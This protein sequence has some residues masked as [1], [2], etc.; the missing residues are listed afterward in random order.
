[1]GLN[2]VN[3]EKMNSPANKKEK[4]VPLVVERP[5]REIRKKRGG[6]MDDE[7][8]DFGNSSSTGTGGEGKKNKATAP[9]STTS[10]SSIGTGIGNGALDDRES[11]R[12]KRSVSA[13]VSAPLLSFWNIASLGY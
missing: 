13:S 3:L 2:Q 9:S 7:L 12:V 1:M 4:V 5:K 8:Y 10:T 11:K 6:M